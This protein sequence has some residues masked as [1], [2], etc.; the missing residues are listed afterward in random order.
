MSDWYVPLPREHG[1]YGQMALPLIT[2]LATAGPST[3]GALLT[4]AVVAA[5]VAHEPIAILLGQRGIRVQ[6]ER[7]AVA[8]GAAAGCAAVGAIAGVGSIL[9]VEPAARWSILIPLLPAIVLGV[10]T[11]RAREKSWHGELAASLAFAGAAVPV[12]MAAG[13]SLADAAVVAIPFALLFV[14]STLAVRTIIVRVRGGGN[15]RATTLTQ[16]SVVAIA[17]VAAVA[18]AWLAAVDALPTSTM[19]AAA[20]GLLMALAV[21]ARPPAPTRLRTVGWTLVGVSILTSLIVV[22]TV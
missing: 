5:F 1:A 14:T 10:T 18:L 15:A 16:R 8:V 12:S 21:S 22:A 13:A 19:A 3:G 6:R 7:R 4:V 11:L 2:A 20:P 9:V 17:A